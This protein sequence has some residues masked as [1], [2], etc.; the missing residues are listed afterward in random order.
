MKALI[1]A[2]GR[3]KRLSETSRDHN[4]CMLSLNGM[5]LIEYSL[6][7]AVSAGAS[8]I[9]IIVG[10]KAEDIINRFGNNYNGV[11]VAYTIQWE[12]KGLV[13]AIEC[14]QERIGKADFMLFLADEVLRNPNHSKMIKKFYEEALFAICGVVMVEDRSQIRNTYSVMQDN[15]D[16]QIYRLVEKPRNPLNNIMGTGN[17]IFRNEIFEYIPY[18]PINQQRGEK[19]LPDLIQCAIDDGRAV[20]SFNIG[21][22]YINVNTCTNLKE[23]EKLEVGL[24]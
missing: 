17:C 10:Y 3:G 13:H 7:N 5:P 8:D 19:E 15:N 14:G 21:D 2:G 23:A 6:Q 16:G 9:L 12:Q 20:K 1:L 18:I 11:K 4:K 24:F 22:S